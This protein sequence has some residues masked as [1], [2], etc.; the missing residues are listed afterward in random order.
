MKKI[1]KEFK[2]FALRGSVID[3]SIGII[4]GAAFNKIV[5]SLVSDIIMPPIGLLLGRVDFSEFYINLSNQEFESLSIAKEAGAPVISYGLFINSLIGFLL[6]AFVVFL[7]IKF[8][9]RVKEKEEEDPQPTPSSKPCQFCFN[10]IPIKA[11]RC[12]FCTST[13]E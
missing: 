2:T 7:L 3:L 11:T 6:T 10:Q 5:N 13:L 9:N 12:P 8:I 4:I 1:F